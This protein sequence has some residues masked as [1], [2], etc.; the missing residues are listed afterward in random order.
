MEDAKPFEAMNDSPPSMRAVVLGAGSVFQV[1]QK[2]AEK[3]GLSPVSLVMLV[4]LKE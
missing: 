2:T 4:L 1:I 3:R